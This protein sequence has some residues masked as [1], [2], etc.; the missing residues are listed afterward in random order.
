LQAETLLDDSDTSGLI[1]C[2]IVATEPAVVAEMVF[3]EKYIA[4]RV[5]ETYNNQRADGRIL[6]LFY[7]PTGSGGDGS[8]PATQPVELMSGVMEVEMQEEAA[9]LYSDRVAQ[10]SQ[11]GR[12][13]FKGDQADNDDGGGSSSSRKN[14]DRPDDRNRDWDRGDRDRERD[15]D[16]D[17]E[18]DR[19]R[20]RDRSY[21]RRDDRTS[22]ASSSYRN[23]S[24][25][26]SR[27]SH[28][29]NGVGGG[30][31]PGR[32]GAGG[33]GGGGGFG[34]PGPFP[35]GGFGGR[36]Y[37]N[38][39]MRGGGGGGRRGGGGGFG[40]GFGGFPSGGYRRGY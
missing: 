1:S 38:D 29:G 19:D 6:R 30:P 10:T 20:D 36:I 5:I 39:M 14:D 8:V 9:P 11:D 25:P 18:R 17:R 7:K 15:R 26:N 22:A 27:P 16:R 24:Y 32:G 13:G 28:Y 2:R 23:T 31:P 3:G 21:D 4:D 33:G 34:A 35:R 37:G 40:G 12:Y